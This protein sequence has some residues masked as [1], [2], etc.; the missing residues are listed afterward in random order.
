[1]YIWV[2]KAAARGARPRSMLR[3]ARQ[4]HRDPMRGAPE[5]RVLAD[6][7]RRSGFDPA[8]QPLRCGA[9]SKHATRYPEDAPA[10]KALGSATLKHVRRPQV[11]ALPYFRSETKSSAAVSGRLDAPRD[12]CCA[13]R[14]ALQAA[15]HAVRARLSAGCVTHA[16]TAHGVFDLHVFASIEPTKVDGPTAAGAEQRGAAPVPAP[17]CACDSGSI[18]MGWVVVEVV[19]EAEAARVSAAMPMRHRCAHPVPAQRAAA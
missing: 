7:A 10:R 2:R 11:P 18:K 8:R 19:A 14:A 9:R 6:D 12:A 4:T 17:A 5:G 13:R 1:M 15:S 16:H 3:R